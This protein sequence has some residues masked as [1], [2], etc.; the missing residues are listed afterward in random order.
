MIIPNTLLTKV[1]VEGFRSLRNVTLDL[2]PINVLIGPN[3]AGKS[4]L[5]T[6]LRLPTIMRT[7]GLRLWVGEQGGASKLLHY[8]PETTSDLEIDLEFTEGSEHWGYEARLRHAAGDKLVF[9]KELLSL[10]SDVR[11]GAV[12]DIG[13]GHDEAQMATAQRPPHTLSKVAEL[14]GGIGYFHFHNTSSTSPLR[15]NSHSAEHQFLRPD[16][17]N[18]ATMLHRFKQTDHPDFQ[19]AWKRI[20]GLVRRVAPFIKDLDAALVAPHVPS[21]TL[22][23]FWTDTRGYRFDAHDLSDGT[24]RAL[25]LIT[26]LA[27]PASMLPKLIVIDEPELGL[28]PAALSLIASVMRSVAHYAQIIVSTQSTALL[29][30]FEPDEVIVVEQDKGESNFRRL[31]PVA[32]EGW[33]E[34]YSLSELYDKNVLGGRP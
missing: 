12:L 18:L 31:D 1:R 33:L 15:Q 7:Q 3:G 10:Q 5:L 8:G 30:E 14:V 9:A 26:A 19:P 22:R 34:E 25:A 28:H 20:E 16:G 27:Q 4:N 21:S 24:L 32:L 17:S 2:A 6:A 29:N 13:A 11:D 23:L